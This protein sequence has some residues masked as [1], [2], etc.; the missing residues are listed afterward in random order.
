MDI[1]KFLIAFAVLTIAVFLFSVLRPGKV[2][3]LY[4]ISRP[5]IQ[6]FIF[7]QYKM[8]SIPFSWLWSM[9]LP[10]TYLLHIFRRDWRIVCPK[11]RPLLLLF[12]LGAFSMIYAIDLKESLEGVIKIMTAYFAFGIA[13]NSVR[14]N[15][16]GLNI[17][18]GMVLSSVVPLSYGFYQK[19]SGNYDQIIDMSVKR[20][21]SVFGVGNAYG[22]YL[23]IVLCATIVLIMNSK[24]KKQW[25]FY[26]LFFCALLASQVLALNRG[27]WIAFTAGSIVAV[28]TF[29]EKVNKKVLL[30]LVVGMGVFA[31]GIVYERFTEVRYRYTGEVAD[32]FQGRV[33]TWRSLVPLIMERPLHGYGVGACRTTELA[34][35]REHIAPHN[36]YVLLA[37]EMGLFGP[38][39]HFFFLSSFIFYYFRRRKKLDFHWKYNFPLLIL[40]VYFL[41]ISSTQNIVYNLTNFVFYNVLNGVAVK[42]NELQSDDES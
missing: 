19:I 42:V 12:L 36:D 16:D 11:S 22:I 29:W 10:I 39:I 31:S 2:L 4:M 25:L 28:F 30:V 1:N 21:S 41:I 23:S 27:T 40:A 26:G 24:T 35:N 7:L 3:K 20:V 14:S 34:G 13:Y 33:E 5:I 8:G 15:T 38:I 32:T 37:I 18:K 6:P 17:L 9:F